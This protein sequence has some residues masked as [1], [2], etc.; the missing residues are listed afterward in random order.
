MN[1]IP[2]LDGTADFNEVVFTDVFVPD[3]DLVGTEGMGW[4]QIGQ[5]L[6][7]ERGGPD[8]WLST[9]LVLEQYLREH[10]AGRA[11]SPRS[12]SSS[13]RRPRASGGCATC[14][15]R[16]RARSTAHGQP[17]VQAALVKEMGT[18]FEQD[19]LESI[20]RFV[21]VEPVPDSSSLF[22][23]LLANAILTAPVFTIRGGTI[24]ILRSVAAKGLRA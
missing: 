22:E 7:F 3:A 5:E 9:Y 4:T 24:E 23:R 18:R 1:P 14:R 16:W 2:F 13:D 11:R 19:L 12:S 6:A 8:R 21:D 10:D 17:S 15:C 20:R